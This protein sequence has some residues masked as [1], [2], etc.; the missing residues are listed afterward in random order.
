MIFITT[1]SR[2]FQFNRLLKAVDLAVKNGLITERVFAQTGS[3]DYGI[4]SYEHVDFLN[5][6]EFN[7][8]LDECDIVL[9]HG[10]TGV[11][12]N[13]A[14]KGKRVVAVPRLAKYGEVVDDHQIELVEAFDKLGIVTP[15][16]DCTAEGIAAAVKAAREK[17][18]APYKSNTQQI[19][20]SIE[21]MIGEA[22]PETT[23]KHDKIR[24]LMCSSARTEKG[25]MNSVIDQLMDHDWGE[26]IELSYLATHVSGSPAKKI[27]YFANAFR[28]LKSLLRRDTFDIIHIHMSYKG[29]FYRKYCVA[30]TCKK[31][32]KKV[33]IHL[34]GSEFKDFYARAND[35]L[36]A[37]ITELFTIAD[38][39]IVLGRDWEAFISEIAPEAKIEVINNAIR[40]P[41]IGD[42]AEHEPPTVLFLGALIKRKGVIDLLQAVRLLTEE[43]TA[44]QVRIAGAGEEEAALKA[45]VRDH[46]LGDVVSF[47][48]WIDNQ[49]KPELLKESDLL[50]LPSYNEGLPIAILEAL[51]YAVPVV[52][53]D[54]GSIAEAVRD[55]EN[56][57]LYT[58]GDIKAL[59]A[60]MRELLTDRELWKR[61]SGAAR[62]TAEDSFSETAFF[63]G[64][65]KIYCA[66]Q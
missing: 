45:F 31:Y 52:S 64:I 29:S 27:L 65:E 23:A 11:I 46:D 7:R 42:K 34:H 25:G 8:R 5:R 32:G 14:K 51:S 35:R 38:R 47:P 26:K 43:K 28:E 49:Q 12:V 62:K 30:K 58:P 4:E 21:E 37:Q 17:E 9:T 41:A 66:L 39:T 55:G 36:K 22:F 3:S 18:P 15:C 44:M 10:G 20:Q 1:G 13:A 48:G 56:G 24:V 60:A 19:I 61:F 54:V 50:V 6:D 53:T 59:S 16:Y 40:I 63:S 2:S 57:F 33:I